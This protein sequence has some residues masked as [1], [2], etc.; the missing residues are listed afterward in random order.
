ML[1]PVIMAEAHLKF[2][3]ELALHY[4]HTATAPAQVGGPL[5]FFNPQ[6]LGT[7]AHIFLSLAAC[8]QQI[9]LHTKFKNQFG[10]SAQATPQTPGFSLIFQLS[11]NR[12]MHALHGNT[13]STILLDYLVPMP[14]PIQISRDVMLRSRLP[15]PPG[16][17]PQPLLPIT[18][19]TA[20]PS[21]EHSDI[22]NSRN[23]RTGRRR[24]RR[25]V[26]DQGVPHFF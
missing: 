2:Y 10:L 9:S 7:G 23:K 20:P 14:T 6:K 15:P 17:S 8:T 16:L 26:D 1:S 22:V 11:R 18:I 4:G 21:I 25:R 12:L 24:R 13:V 5:K 19:S 3:Q